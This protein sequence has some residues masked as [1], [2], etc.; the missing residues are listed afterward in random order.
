TLGKRISY[1][2]VRSE[3]RTLD[4][5]EF[6]RE[7]LGWHEDPPNEDEPE[8][9][10]KAKAA[11]PGLADAETP[12]PAGSTVMAVDVPKDRSATV[13]AVAWRLGDRV[14]VMLTVLK[15]TSKAAQTIADLKA[16]HEP[17]DVSLH[18][19]G[20]AGALVKPLEDLG[21]EVRTVST[22]ELAQDTGTF[23]D[24]VVA[25]GVGHLDQPEL[26]GSFAGAKLRDVGDSRVWDLKELTSLAPVRA[27]TLAVAGFVKFGGEV[28]PWGVFA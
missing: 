19:G 5:V 17:A 8:D 7:R 13:I 2:Y 25:G 21:V 14:M 12:A 26:N 3:R 9:L 23:I 27:A 4:P 18:A 15:G 11:W 6:G 24:L 1:D 22:Q 10:A 20:P 16:A 28:E